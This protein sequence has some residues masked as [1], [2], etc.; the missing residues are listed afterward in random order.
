M[1]TA[2]PM[3]ACMNPCDL[4][5]LY[6]RTK[7]VQ[8]QRQKDQENFQT[9]MS[10]MNA[11]SLR[12]EAKGKEASEESER[13]AT[14][15]SQLKEALAK[16]QQLEEERIRKNQDIVNEP[17]ETKE[18]RK[19]DT[20]RKTPTEDSSSEEEAESGEDDNQPHMT[21]QDGQEVL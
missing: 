2:T 10:S 6:D 20:K 5:S 15:Q 17:K 19:A 7:A 13:S 3:H 21:T 9:M 1:Y 12:L 4:H 16:V 11:L 8:A 14:L 18:S